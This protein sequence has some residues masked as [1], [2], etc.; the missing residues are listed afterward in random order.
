[1]I[2][3]KAYISIDEW[4]EGRVCTSQSNVIHTNTNQEGSV[5]APSPTAVELPTEVT[6]RTPTGSPADVPTLDD[7]TS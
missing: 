6:G 1:M 7:P 5:S 4:L 2:K 3:R